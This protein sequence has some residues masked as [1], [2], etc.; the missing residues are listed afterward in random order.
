MGD[1][2]VNTY[3]ML[4]ALGRADTIQGVAKLEREEGRQTDLQK[5]YKEAVTQQKQAN[6]AIRGAYGVLEHVDTEAS[7]QKLAEAKRKLG[8]AQQKQAELKKRMKEPPSAVV[9][10]EIPGLKV[11]VCTLVAPDSPPEK[12][13]DVYIHSKLMIVDDVF[14]TLGSANINTRSM[15]A[16]TELNICHES[17]AAT[18][19]LRQ[20]LWKIHTN[21]LGERDDP[22][23]AFEQWGTIIMRNAD[24]QSKGLAPVASLV[25]FHRDDPKRTNKD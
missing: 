23:A 8:Q 14:T 19:P 20:R 5:Q 21:G 17:A 22:A 16:D 11:H 2:T 4:E 25:Q 6:Q 10:T 9:P 12:W 18:R 13:Q 1:G 24:N 3:R 15:E 7:R